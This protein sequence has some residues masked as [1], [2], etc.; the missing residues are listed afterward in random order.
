M[1]T[2]TAQSEKLPTGGEMRKSLCKK[3]LENYTLLPLITG[4]PYPI[5]LTLA[6]AEIS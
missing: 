2:L 3:T 4:S 6:V 1:N 5:T